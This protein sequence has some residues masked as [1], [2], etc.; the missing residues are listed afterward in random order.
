MLRKIKY[1]STSNI[2]KIDDDDDNNIDDDHKNNEYQILVKRDNRIETK[3]LRTN[4]SW[5]KQQQKITVHC[6]KCYNLVS[7]LVHVYSSPPKAE[8][9]LTQF[10]KH[11]TD[12]SKG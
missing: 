7:L 11:L 12:I 9:T 8:H 4:T 5:I 1:Q 2:S 10:N 3:C 6:M